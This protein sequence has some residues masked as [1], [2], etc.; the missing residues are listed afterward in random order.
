MRTLHETIA[1]DRSRDGR[2]RRAHRRPVGR[3]DP[4]RGARRPL[5]SRGGGA[6]RARPR[7]PATC[8]P[9][10]RPTRPNGS[11]AALGAMAVGAAVTGASPL[12][13]RARA[14][15]AAPGLRG[16]DP[17]RRSRRRLSARARGRRAT[18]GVRGRPGA[19]RGRGRRA[20]ARRCRST[21]RR[22]VALLPY[23]SGTTG[24]PKGVM[25]THANLVAARRAGSR[26][27]QAR[28]RATPSLAVA[29][30]SHVM[31]FVVTLSCAL[32]PGRHGRHHAA[33]RAS[34]RSSSSI[35][36]HRVTRPS[37]SRRPVLARWPAHPAVDALRPLDARARRL[38]RRAR[39][40][41]RSRAPC[42]RAAARRRRSP[43]GYGLTETSRDGHRARPRSPSRRAR[44]GRARAA[45]H[46]AARSS[47]PTRAPISAPAS[48]GELWV[49]GPRRMAR[50]PATA[51]TPR[52]R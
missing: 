47:T 13:H 30:F 42:A 9:S 17:R 25:L 43:Q 49:R 1:G 4:L 12:G 38:G 36:R 41:P 35:E 15:R 11:I 39:W 3:N 34:S 46:R 48:R 31:G 10:G 52:P 23:S 27:A 20:L 16:V 14:G 51:R 26:P 33:L 29:P 6:R 40:R 22:A 50:L 45:R 28:R 37:S 8:S 7:R 2:S 24:L 19:R 5:R 21:P 32:T 44:L 18:A